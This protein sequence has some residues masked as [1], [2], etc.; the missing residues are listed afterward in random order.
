MFCNN[1]MKIVV[2]QLKLLGGHYFHFD[3]L[4]VIIM[5]EIKGYR[6]RK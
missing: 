1:E 2:A 5:F 3:R 6:P 4:T